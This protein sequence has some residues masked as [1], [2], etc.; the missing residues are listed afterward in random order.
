MSVVFVYTVVKE[1]KQVSCLG[2]QISERSVVLTFDVGGSYLP[3][4]IILL[5]EGHRF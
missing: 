3:C 4:S 5:V 2:G 1:K